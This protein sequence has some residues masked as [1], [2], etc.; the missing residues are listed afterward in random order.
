VLSNQTCEQV[1]RG[2]RRTHERGFGVPDD[3]REYFTNVLGAAGYG[4]MPRAEQCCNP[5]LMGPFVVLVV[6][7]GN[8]ERLELVLCITAGLEQLLPM[9]PAR[10][11]HMRQRA[12]PRAA[13][14]E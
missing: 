11:S 3:F 5:F 8:R 6:G 7:K 1:Q 14:S 2:R 9:N 12:H 4:V 13:A 10:H